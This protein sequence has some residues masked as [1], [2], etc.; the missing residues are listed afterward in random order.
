MRR[1]GIYSTRPPPDISIFVFVVAAI[2]AGS[3]AYGLWS[4]YLSFASGNAAL[5]F[6]ELSLTFI[7]M[8]V[9]FLCIESIRGR[10]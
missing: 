2:C 7:A 8:R 1:L 3:A 9:C 10:F 4:T 5:G 6:L